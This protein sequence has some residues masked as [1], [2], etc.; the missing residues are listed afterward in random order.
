MTKH[1]YADCECGSDLISSAISIK[2]KMGVKRSYFR[3]L[4]DY[5]KTTKPSSLTSCW[6]PSMYLNSVILMWNPECYGEH[7]VAWFPAAEDYCTLKPLSLLSSTSLFLGFVWLLEIFHEI[8]SPDLI[9]LEDG[10]F[11]LLCNKLVQR[12]ISCL[13]QCLFF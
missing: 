7:S 6:T 1:N 11:T 10:E 12:F 13:K 9:Y 4:I 3:R 5:N 2:L 8:S